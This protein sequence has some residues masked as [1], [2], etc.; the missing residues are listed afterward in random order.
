MDTSL[1]NGNIW[2]SIFSIHTPPQIHGLIIINDNFKIPIIWGRQRWASMLR[3]Y[4]RKSHLESDQQL[5]CR[6]I[7]ALG[8]FEFTS[9][10][11]DR[12]SYIQLIYPQVMEYCSSRYSIQTIYKKFHRSAHNQLKQ[13][14]EFH[15]SNAIHH[16]L[17][18]PLFPF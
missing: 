8:T 4:A 6:A 7:H 15:L 12:F 17:F 11:V 14:T 5:F 16:R 1:L 3:R 18:L 9:I 2:K 13:D 10:L